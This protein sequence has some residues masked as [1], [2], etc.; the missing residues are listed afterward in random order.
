MSDVGLHKGINGQLKTASPG[1]W[2]DGGNAPRFGVDVLVLSDDA[3]LKKPERVGGSEG[4]KRPDVDGVDAL[5]WGEGTGDG[6]AGGILQLMYYHIL[7][8]YIYIYRTGDMNPSTPSQRMYNTP[9]SPSPISTV[10]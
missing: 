3:L 1:A 10:L 9:F 4:L 2:K 7:Y 8:M 5:G 6:E